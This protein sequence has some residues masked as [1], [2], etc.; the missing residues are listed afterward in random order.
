VLKIYHQEVP[1]KPDGQTLDRLKRT[2]IYVDDIQLPD[3]TKHYKTKTVLLFD[4]TKVG[5]K[6]IKKKNSMFK[7][8]HQNAEGPQQKLS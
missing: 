7:S 8:R 3:G 5:K 2:S 6:E 4:S 1:R